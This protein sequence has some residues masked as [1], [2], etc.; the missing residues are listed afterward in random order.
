LD[1]L[2]GRLGL[3]FVMIAPLDHS[4]NGNDCFFL[5]RH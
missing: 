4:E 1:F 2:L 5:L 3:V